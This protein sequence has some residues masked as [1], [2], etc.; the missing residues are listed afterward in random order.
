MSPKNMFYPIKKIL[1][2]TDGSE[3]SIK[4]AKYC[5]EIAIKHESVVTLLHVLEAFSAK[6]ERLYLGSDLA[7]ASIAVEEEKKIKERGKK[8]IESTKKVFEGTIVPLSVKYFFGGNPARII[9]EIAEKENYDLIVIGHRGIGG[10][11]RL[12]IG[13]VTNEVSRMATCPVFIVK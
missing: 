4:A 11:K 8:I 13:S 12:M 9:V 1:L 6:K 2:P 10:V 3:Y 7:L 5:A